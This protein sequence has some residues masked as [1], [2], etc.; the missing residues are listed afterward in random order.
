M[1]D[2]L[3]DLSVSDLVLIYSFLLVRERRQFVI[4]EHYHA[5]RVARLVLS[6]GF[7]IPQY[8]AFVPLWEQELAPV[9]IALVARVDNPEPQ[10]EPEPYQWA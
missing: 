6:A 9:P 5:T 10:S 4:V 1:T 3:G 8:I 2:Q 7:V